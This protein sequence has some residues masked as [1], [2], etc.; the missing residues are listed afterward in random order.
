MNGFG[1]YVTWCVNPPVLVGCPVT[2]GVERGAAAP[3]WPLGCTF[4]EV[5]LPGSQSSQAAFALC[6]AMM[7]AVATW[8]RIRAMCQAWSR[9]IQSRLNRLSNV[10]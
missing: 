10:L 3:G 9:L 1:L 7:A 2:R 8:F 4:L 6:P 5:E